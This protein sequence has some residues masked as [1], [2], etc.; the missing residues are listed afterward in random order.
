MDLQEEKKAWR[1]EKISKKFVNAFRGFYIFT[2]MTKHFF[3]V[4]LP[5]YAIAIILGF[6]ALN[7]IKQTGESGRGFAIAGIIIGF[8]TI[9]LGLLALI[10]VFTVFGFVWNAASHGNAI[11]EGFNTANTSGSFNFSFPTQ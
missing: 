3:Y 10:M 9:G 7:Q 5:I 2:K 11:L 1:E 6:V 8:V 4:H